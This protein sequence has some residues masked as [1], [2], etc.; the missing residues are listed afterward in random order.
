MLGARHACTSR[1]PSG[2][3]PLLHRSLS[4]MSP[5]WTPITDRGPRFRQ[6]V[7]ARQIV[8]GPMK[9]SIPEDR[10]RIL[11][12]NILAESLAHEFGAHLYRGTS[13]HELAWDR[14]CA[15][16]LK[17]IEAHSPDVLCLQEVDH[18]TQLKR[19]L[20]A[21]GYQ[22]RYLKRTGAR[23]DGLAIFWRTARL[24]Q[25]FMDNI[26]FA[27]SGLRDNVAQVATFELLPAE[28]QGREREGSP[29]P[30]SPPPSPG[31]PASSLREEV[32]Q[33]QRS[34]A[35]WQRR[36]RQAAGEGSGQ[37]SPRQPGSDPTGSRG[38]ATSA[39]AAA[40]ILPFTFIV[41]NVHV[42]FNP[43][44]GDVKLAQTRNL[45]HA[46][47]GASRRAG[48]AP[49]V[50]CGDFNSAAYSDVHCFIT[51]GELGLQAVDRRWASGQVE[52]IGRGWYRM[53][54]RLLDELASGVI[55]G[56]APKVPVPWT[57]EELA[58]AFARL[59][60]RPGVEEEGG[61]EFDGAGAGGLNGAGAGVGSS[62][63][64]PRSGDWIPDGLP[65]TDPRRKMLLTHPLTLRSAYQAVTG[66]EPVW[67]TC[68]DG[69]MGTVD[70]IFYSLEPNGA[71][72]LEPRG[73]L[74]PPVAQSLRSGL[75]NAH[76]PSDHVCLVADFDARR[77]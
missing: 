44:R 35:Q 73:V 61:E 41:S 67:T 18:F 28:E 30:S 50:V 70:Y 31:R 9:A 59:R 54:R 57:E 26:R 38:E 76:W 77:A 69:Y 25:V 75:P 48:G 40:A 13:A 23:V 22:G 62:A 46:V 66:E 42:L 45:L 20:A 39:A 19:E 17:E 58:V 52:G 51:S 15:A 14:R 36:R 16:F 49:A 24:R 11:S 4:T 33:Q 29:V 64:G 12:Y 10:L 65:D 55:R 47:H 21:R 63:G 1:L 56:Y 6:Y 32:L 27:E 5:S 72:S 43:K 68:H 74:L 34:W 2:V 53:R 7:R 8:L 37:A 71:P 60:S 3:V